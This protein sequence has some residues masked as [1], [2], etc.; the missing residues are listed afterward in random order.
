MQDQFEIPRPGTAWRTTVRYLVAVGLLVSCF[1][2][3]FW[4]VSQRSDVAV[5][6][7]VVLTIGAVG[8]VAAFTSYAARDIQ[9]NSGLKFA[10]AA[11]LLWQVGCGYKYIEPGY[12][13]IV[14][15]KYGS[16]KGV[17]DFPVVTGV[18]WYLPWATAIYEYP[19]FVQT[20][21]WT[22]DVR[23][24][25]PNDEAIRYNSKEGLV[26]IADISL[27]YHLDGLRVPGFYVQFRS[28]NLDRFTHGLMHN[29][30]R[31][32]F[33]EQA[34]L[35][36][37]EELYST[38]K[39]KLLNDAKDRINLW[40]EKYGVVIDQFGYLGAPRPPDQIVSAINGK[41]QATQ[42]AMRV[43]NEVAKARA[44]ALKNVATAEGDAKQAI[45]RAE[46]QAQ[47]NKV[48][49]Q[50]LSDPLMRWRELDLQQRSID[51]WA[52]QMPQVI[53]ASG[54]LLYNIP[55]GGGR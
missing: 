17:Q 43:E 1:A 13:G 31:D 38:K 2:T 45:A 55:T 33:N 28:D 54:T 20:A 14:V 10:L 41:I 37:S 30:A 51:K 36:T 34:P 5:A 42:D 12:V 26:F 35:Y 44:E 8:A 49:A 3:G 7:G 22:Q 24:E 18:Q 40:V 23:P 9:K 15:D 39:E 27:S 25:S 21:V 6:L 29:L 47:A 32:A 16:Q 48:L 11:L 50:S 4:L 46:G 19:T 52:G 53:G